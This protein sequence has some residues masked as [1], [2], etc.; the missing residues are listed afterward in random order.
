MDRIRKGWAGLW[1]SIALGA[2]ANVA[3]VPCAHSEVLS[4]GAMCLALDSDESSW[5]WW[6]SAARPMWQPALVNYEARGDCAQAEVRRAFEQRV[7]GL[8]YCIERWR[9]AGAAE[10]RYFD[11]SWRILTDGSTH[12]MATAPKGDPDQKVA[13]C[14][15]RQVARWMFKPVAEVSTVTCTGDPMQGKAPAEWTRPTVCVPSA[16]QSL[17]PVS[18][19]AESMHATCE[20]EITLMVEG[21]SPQGQCERHHLQNDMERQSLE[22]D[23][24]EAYQPQPW[25]GHLNLV[26]GPDGRRVLPESPSIHTWPGRMHG[27]SRIGPRVAPQYPACFA[28]P[29][30]LANAVIDALHQ[31][32]LDA[33]DALFAFDDEV[34]RTTDATP[35]LA[36]QPPAPRWVAQTTAAAPHSEDTSHA[37]SFRDLRT[38][39]QQLG[40]ARPEVLELRAVRDGQGPRPL[41]APLLVSNAPLQDIEAALDLN[42]TPLVLE[43]EGVFLVRRGFVLS[44]LR[45]RTDA[46][47]VPE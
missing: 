22:S 24:S 38:R 2:L 40:D 6:G 5:W 36:C 30:I 3:S 12:A 46:Q 11:V 18:A 37:G 32:D 19:L 42:G 17:P 4:T 39:L 45:L 15:Q 21:K 43:M 14:M 34:G 28:T 31:G 16:E 9:P 26:L 33:F 35:A 25:P 23:V 27:R 8:Q 1:L 13:G 47:R 7:S 20:V 29:R 10:R 44:G 41:A